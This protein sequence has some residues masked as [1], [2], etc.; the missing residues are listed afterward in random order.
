MMR[1]GGKVLSTDVADAFSSVKGGPLEETIKAMGYY[2]DVIVLR[3]YESD[4][5]K[6][7]AKV[8]SVPTMGSIWCPYRC[9]SRIFFYAIRHNSV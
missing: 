2:S 6:R 1:L 4:S 9:P 3:N 5:A 8:S 7:A